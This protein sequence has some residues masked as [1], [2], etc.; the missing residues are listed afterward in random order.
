MKLIVGLGNPGRKYAKNRHNIGF[1]AVDALADELGVEVARRKFT[2]KYIQAQY[3]GC[4][5]LLV[6]PQTFM[7]L[8]GTSV[9]SFSSYFKVDPEDILIIVDDVH[10]SFKKLRMRINSSAGGHNG[11]QSVID[12]LSGNKGFARLRV[13]VNSPPENIDLKDY[14]LSDFLKEERD[15][16]GDL[17]EDITRATLSWVTRGAH[18]VM[19]EIN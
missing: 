4:D 11:I 3:E 7:N 16:L 1:M 8:S 14:V 5:V 15:S 12:E 9:F 10:L 17:C 6:K 19:Q 13:G 2:A 18:S